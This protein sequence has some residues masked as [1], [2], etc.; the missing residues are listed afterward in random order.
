MS[1]NKLKF[2]LDNV[3]TKFDELGLK[4]V[5]R[6]DND[7]KV[8]LSISNLLYSYTSMKDKITLL[9]AIIDV[10]KVNQLIEVSSMSDLGTISK[11]DFDKMNRL[12]TVVKSEIKKLFTDIK[13][14]DVYEVDMAKL[15]Q[16][17]ERIS[18]LKVV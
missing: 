5:W 8:E 1:F 12:F 9:S 17:N 14:M 2:F 15:D 3:T 10:W 11:I 4:V 16:F 18:K 6:D 13:D 7:N